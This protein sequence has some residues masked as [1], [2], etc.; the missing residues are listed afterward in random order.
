MAPRRRRDEYEFDDDYGDYFED[1]DLDLDE[2]TGDQFD[3]EEEVRQIDREYGGAGVEAE[4]IEMLRGKHPEDRAAFLE[5]LRAKQERRTLS[6]GP[7]EAG[8]YSTD[9]PDDPVARQVEITRR[10]AAAAAR[11]PQQ[12]APSPYS[13]YLGGAGGAPPAAAGGLGTAAVSPTLERDPLIAQLLERQTADRARQETE[14]AEMREMIM[15]QLAE[16]TAPVDP[17]S[18][19]ISPILDAQ[20]LALRRS[21]DRQRSAAV[22]QAGARGLGDSGTIATRLNQ[23]AQSRGEAEAGFVAQVLQN[24]LQAKRGQAQ[25]LL[26][27]AVQSGDAASARALQGQLT[28]LD[29]QMTQVRFAQDLGFR[30]TALG[31]D[32]GLRGRGLDLQQQNLEG[33]RYR[34]DQDL[35][36]R[37]LMAELLGNQAAGTNLMGQWR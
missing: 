37:L 25:Q 1:Y 19:A 17:T 34:F 29:Q 32:V 27:L 28:A 26:S 4:D 15:S 33:Q 2:D 36:Y 20:R 24:E 16:A 11:P 12:Q 7:R 31:Q 30:E 23:I 5:D 22:E 14:R 13:Q 21:A 6:G 35:A 18:A 9:L 8:G 10:A 3:V